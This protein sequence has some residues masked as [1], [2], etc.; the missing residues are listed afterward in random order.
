MDLDDNF[1][2][3][4]DTTSESTRSEVRPTRR[5]ANTET[6]TST[7][8]G[9]DQIVETVLRRLGQ[10][11]RPPMRQIPPTAGPYKCRICGHPN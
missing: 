10:T 8:V 3:G 9:P 2:D 7:K 4:E 6:T 1:D 5:S 11:Y